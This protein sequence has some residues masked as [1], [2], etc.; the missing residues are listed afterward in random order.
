MTKEEKREYNKKYYKKN[1]DAILEQNKQYVKT[2]KEDILLYRKQYRKDNIDKE[3]QY[4][5][6]NHENILKNKKQYVK[7]H[8]ESIANYRKQYRNDNSELCLIIQAKY[9]AKKKGIPFNLSIEDIIVPKH[10]PILGIEIKYGEGS[11]GPIDGSPTIDKID[12]NKGYI[13]GN[14]QV[15]S[16]KANRMKFNA[17]FMELKLFAKNVFKK[18]SDN[19][20]E[21]SIISTEKY[22]LRS[23]KGHAKK[24][25]LPFNLSIEDI[26]IPKYCPILGMELKCE[27][28]RFIESSPTLDKINPV[29]GYI[30]GNIRVI[31]YKANMMKNNANSEELKK[32][33][34]WINENIKL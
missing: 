11:K 10:C 30:K 7:D 17:T 31:S 2:H 22:M 32:F 24:N 16:H 9:R 5:K 20:E 1:R 19:F 34:D 29:L 27:K 28:G 6:N 33:C 25:K 26:V 4:R 3:K 8:K 18:Y 13:K 23:A 12:P 21:K 15:I 14:V